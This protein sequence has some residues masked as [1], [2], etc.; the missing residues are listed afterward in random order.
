MTNEHSSAEMYALI[1]D[2]E[3]QMGEIARLQRER[4]LIVGRATVR[5]KRITVTVNADGIIIGVEFSS[6]ITD[7]SYAEIAT[8]V[9]D[10]TQQ[11]AADA[12]R[13]ARELMAPL[14]AHRARM[15][16]LSD[17]VDGIPDL[18]ALMP[19]PVPAPITPA[20]LESDRETMTFTDV[21]A[22]DHDRTERSGVTDASW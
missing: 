9:V 13:R 20:R 7:L 6:R 11:A 21:E 19:K 17:L 2:F 10:A 5:G 22:F 18:T 4:N 15:P 3:K 8:A 12:T 14:L 16:K 1:D